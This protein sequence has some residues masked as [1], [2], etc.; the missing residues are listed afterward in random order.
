MNQEIVN[1]YGLDQPVSGNR[2]GAAVA[3]GDSVS[4]AGSTVS[5]SVMEQNLSQLQDFRSKL[6]LEIKKNRPEKD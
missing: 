4:K 5:K 3:P 6:G 1:N 2:L